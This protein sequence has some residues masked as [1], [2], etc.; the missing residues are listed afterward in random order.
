MSHEAS[1]WA[2][3]Q[4]LKQTKKLVL[5]YLADVATEEF[6]AWPSVT[7]LALR[8][9]D[10]S[11]RSVRGIL[12]ELEEDKLIERDE[13]FRKDGSQASNV[14]RLLLPGGRNCSVDDVPIEAV[15]GAVDPG[16]R[17]PSSALDPSVDPVGKKSADADEEDQSPVVEVWAHYVA[18]MQPRRAAL[19]EQ[20]RR[21]IRDALKVATA[22]E[23]TRAIDGCKA[24][25]FHM[26]QNE[27]RKAYNKLSQIVRGR[28]GKETTRERIDFFIEIADKAGVA[29]SGVQSA[30]P[31]KVKDNKRR[32][33]AGWEFPNDAIVVRQAQAAEAWLKEAGIVVDRDEASGRPT[34]RWA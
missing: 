15:E 12:R 16:G 33:M 17:N 21:L 13:R 31:V 8:C 5:L 34:F 18:V 32:V 2:W 27:R 22:V 23:L 1:T 4:D 20:E 24:S 3:A 11:T 10:V 19:D 9:G 6:I 28:R 7:K 25:S 30:D 26:G 29:K 14:Y